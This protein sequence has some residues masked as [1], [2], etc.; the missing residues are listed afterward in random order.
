MVDRRRRVGGVDALLA[1]ALGVE[2]SGGIE[3]NLGHSIGHGLF[4]QRLQ[5]VNQPLGEQVERAIDIGLLAGFGQ[6]GGCRGGDV[7]ESEG[8][9]GHFQRLSSNRSSLTPRK[10]FGPTKLP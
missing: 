7:V 9:L 1:F 5:R 6:R 8:S 10:V 3:P 4:R 2:P